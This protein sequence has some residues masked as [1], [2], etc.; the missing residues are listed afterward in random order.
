LAIEGRKSIEPN[1]N[2]SSSSWKLGGRITSSFRIT[3]AM[4]DKRIENLP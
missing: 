4:K 2:N 1:D 3:L